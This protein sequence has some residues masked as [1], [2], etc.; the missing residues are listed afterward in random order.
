MDE[1]VDQKWAEYLEIVDKL[2][3]WELDELGFPLVKKEGV[4][5]TKMI[6]KKKKE[7]L[8]AYN[9]AVKAG[10][11]GGQL[12]P[13]EKTYTKYGHLETIRLAK[14]REIRDIRTSPIES[15]VSEFIHNFER[16][17]GR[18]AGG[19]PG[20]KKAAAE[21]PGKIEQHHAWANIEGS[22]FTTMLDQVGRAHKL[23]AWRYIA[24]EY[25]TVP[26]YALTNMW[27]LPGKA[28][29]THKLLHSWMRE[30]G[31]EYYWRD[32]VKARPKMTAAEQFQRI[33]QFFEDVYYP[34]IQYAA[35]LALD[36]PAVKSLRDINMNKKLL[37][38]SL[39]ASPDKPLAKGAIKKGVKAVYE[40]P[41]GAAGRKGWW[42]D[43]AQKARLREWLES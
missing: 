4:E 20:S 3:N 14:L 15:A 2:D 8:A 22:T 39:E 21:L 33:D 32:L 31:F 29:Q 24:K 18:A 25:G 12:R 40:D 7:S 19:V 30:M 26:G 10:K 6:A 35:L 9:K 17:Y 23:D 42:A 41:M 5:I 38:K 36:D 43:E 28:G 34:T 16:G 27:N 11:R 13:F 37:R 1:L